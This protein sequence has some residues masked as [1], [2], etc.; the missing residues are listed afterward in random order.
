MRKN[1]VIRNEETG[2]SLTMLESEYDN[3]GKRQVYRVELPAHRPSPPL[4]YH[5]SF[6]ETFSVLEGNLD[7]YLG[8]ERKHRLLGKGESVIVQKLEL[9]TFANTSDS[10]CTMQVETV[11]AG[12]VVRPFQLAYGVAN[13]GNAGADGLRACIMTRGQL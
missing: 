7:V 5:V 6:A 2:E 3:G 12:G 13:Q 11:P 8:K 1:Q 9:H 10:P 4:H